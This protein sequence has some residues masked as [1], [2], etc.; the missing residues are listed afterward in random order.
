MSM[1]F[2][3]ENKRI[4][5]KDYTCSLCYGKI[6]AGEK[7]FRETGKWDG[8]FFSRAMH[9][10]CHM[11]VDEY[12]AEV[13]PEYTNDDVQDYFLDEYCSQCESADETIAENGCENSIYTCP[14]IFE[15]LQGNRTIS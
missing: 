11:M 1:E 2:Y 9:I 7:Y 8:E 5:K 6:K 15:A 10:Q 14:K 3:S 4:A 12:C 13:E